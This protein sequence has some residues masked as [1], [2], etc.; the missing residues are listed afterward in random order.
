[1]S[2]SSGSEATR[3]GDLL[4]GALLYGPLIISSLFA[5]LRKTGAIINPGIWV[6]LSLL[7]VST[8]FMFGLGENMAGALVGL[9]NLV[10]CW[11]MMIYLI[12]TSDRV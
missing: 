4:A 10:L 6:V 1:M 2:Y 9:F 3:Q 5:M 11:V 12:G 8:A 7:I